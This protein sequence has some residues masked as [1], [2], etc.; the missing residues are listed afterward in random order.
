MTDVTE[1]IRL[2]VDRTDGV[3]N[4]A[5]GFPFLLLKAIEEPAE[6]ASQ[7][8]HMENTNTDKTS[9]PAG[10]ENQESTKSPDVDALVKA[11]VAEATKGSEE[12]IKTLETELAKVKALPI[13]GGP[14]MTAPATM[15]N[16]ASKAAKLV[17]AAHFTK[18]AEQVTDQD[19]KKYYKERA[20]VCKEA[21]SA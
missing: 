8:E 2:D 17:E 1:I 6:K 15:R 16:E 4:P 19:L 20:K 10:G 9:A 11:A 18:L 14:V 21:A 3:K 7:E 5:N 12:R 13:P